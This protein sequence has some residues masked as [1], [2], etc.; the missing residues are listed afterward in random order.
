M[1]SKEFLQKV[2]KQMEYYLSDEN[3]K[4][5][6]FFHG[7]ISSSPEG[8]VPIQTFLNCNKI[9]KLGA[10]TEQIQQAVE[11]ASSI[12]LS[13][14]KDAIRRKNNKPVPVL[15]S[16]KVYITFDK[17]C[18]I[19]KQEN[20]VLFVPHILV[21]KT[22]QDMFF[23]GRDLERKIK[24][25]L[26]IDIPYV[27]VGKKNGYLV[28]NKLE[29]DLEALEDLIKTGIKIDKFSIDLS[30]LGQEESQGWLKANRAQ[31]EAALK[32]KYQYAVIKE[33]T[34][35]KFGLDENY[36]PVTLDGKTFKDV[37]E[38]KNQL[39]LII[40]KTRNGEVLKENDFNFVKA[41]VKYHNKGE[42]KLKDLVS[43]QVDTNPKFPATRCFFVVKSD[44]ARDDFSFH[45][46]LEDFIESQKS[47]QTA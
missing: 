19:G 8:Y 11:L 10:T 16:K 32:Q 33:K 42:E 14:E 23:K 40:C 3:L 37:R 17:D 35:K 15:R 21:F 25:K 7:Q 39:K 30:E 36:G 34:D 45:K 29:A 12:E 46:C 5:D 6:A 2:Q 41:L 31:L 38:L 44:G 43:I 9:I 22:T 47:T 26:V 13:S 27:K 4:N 28:F 1:D 18:E 24:K 20:V